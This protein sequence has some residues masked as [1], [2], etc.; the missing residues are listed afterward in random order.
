MTARLACLIGGTLLLGI[1]CTHD[2]DQYDFEGDDEGTTTTTTTTTPMGG[3]GGVGGAGGAG[4]PVGGSGGQECVG[5]FECPGTDTDCR[6]RT[7]IN[8]VCGFV[9]KSLNSD[10]NDNGGL[11]CNGNGQCVECNTS[12]QCV[13][14]VCDMGACAMPECTDT[15]LNGD[16]T[17]V[18]CGGATCPG[19]MN[20][21]ACMVDTDCDSGYCDAA[22]LCAAP[23][24]SD[25]VLN[26]DETAV[27]CGGATCP[28]C[29]NGEAC[30]VG[31][32]CASGYCDG[33]MIC[34]ACGGDGDCVAANTWC[35]VGVCEAQKM[36]GDACS[37]A[38][39]CLN[40]NC[41]T[42]DGVCCDAPCAALCES[43]V[44]AKNGQANDGICAV[45][46]SGTDPDDEC[47]LDATACSGDA[48]GGVAG[49]CGPAPGATVCRIGA[50][51]C[52]FPESCDGTNLGCPNDVF[53]PDGTASIGGGC[54]PY[55]CDGAQA[56]CPTTCVGDGD[57]VPTS[58]CNMGQMTCQ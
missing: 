1:A 20:G 56:G 37:G 25:V 49:Q 48:C 9:D 17:A 19:C 39:E 12:D 24:C 21:E 35:N 30:L 47:T 36:D 53:L 26:G 38:N 42:Q 11:F 34:A 45:T 33:S 40:G 31:G 44:A 18:D 27:D 16:E 28:G 15:V 10:C 43:C 46:T 3:F 14:M 5:P 6:Q 23:T 13:S 51:D 50:G 41:P 4:G 58:S 55:L 7:C 29:M 52:D 2:F 8:G 57:C 32:D 54:D 22:N